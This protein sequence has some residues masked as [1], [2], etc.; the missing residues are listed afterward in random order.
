MLEEQVDSRVLALRLSSLSKAV[1]GVIEDG[2]AQRDDGE[3][4]KCEITDD[5]VD[6]TG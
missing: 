4:S 6:K 1:G 2:I 3:E 5:Y